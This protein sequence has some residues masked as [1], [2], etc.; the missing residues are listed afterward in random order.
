MA[1]PGVYHCVDCRRIVSAFFSKQHGRG[2]ACHLQAV[3]ASEGTRRSGPRGR[4]PEAGAGGSRAPAR[5]SPPPATAA[6]AST[7]ILKAANSMKMVPNT[8]R[9]GEGPLRAHVHAPSQLSP[10][11]VNRL[12]HALFGLSSFRR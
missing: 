9:S 3:V 8:G 5:L 6:R 12:A 4:G 1:R 11:S 2:C 7:V 10:P